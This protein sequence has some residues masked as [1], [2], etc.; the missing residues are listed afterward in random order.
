MS[1]SFIRL[2]LA[3]EKDHPEGSPH[4]GYEIIAPL[5]ANGHLNSE[6][7][8]QN[9]RKCTVRRF[10][11]NEPDQLGEFVH[12][13]KGHWAISYD[14]KTDLDDEPIYRLDR[15][16]ILPGEYISISEPNQKQH[17][18]RVAVVADA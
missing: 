7:W 6:A 9:R 1:L 18:F 8:K 10:W 12:T 2:E 11:Q 5:D 13:A 15:H 16:V 3:R 17:T 14:P 4:H